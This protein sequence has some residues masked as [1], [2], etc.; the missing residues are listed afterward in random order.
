MTDQCD[1]AHK[2][3]NI[4]Q[5]RLQSSS[6]NFNFW[7]IVHKMFVNLTKTSSMY[8]QFFFLIY[9]HCNML[10]KAINFKHAL[11]IQ[12]LHKSSIAIICVYEHV[13]F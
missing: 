7:C 12:Y 9:Y 2:D 6:T 5:V 3:Q 1:T 13:Y 10:H 11:Y 4:V 8:R